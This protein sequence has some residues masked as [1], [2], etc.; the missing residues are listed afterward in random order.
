M[1]CSGPLDE[2]FAPELHD[3]NKID[4]STGI[5]WAANS[6]PRCLILEKL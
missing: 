6:V 4:N 2:K 5:K 3:K 1:T